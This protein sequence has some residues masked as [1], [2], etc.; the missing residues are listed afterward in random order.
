MLTVALPISK[1]AFN[2]KGLLNGHLFTCDPILVEIS[3]CSDNFVNENFNDFDE[4][5]L[6]HD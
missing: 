3:H 5:I 1:I 4:V 2:L 6:F